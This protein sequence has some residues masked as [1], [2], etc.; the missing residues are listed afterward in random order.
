MNKEGIV[1]E[2]KEYFP[3]N[4]QEMKDKELILRWIQENEDAFLRTNAIGHVTVSAWVVNKE[5]DKVLMVYHNIYD[6][7]SWLGGHADGETDLLSVALR[8]VKEEAGVMNIKPISSD[9]LSLEVLTVD[10][11]EKKGEYVSSHLH[12]NVTCLLEGDSDE[13][14]V[15]KPDENS[16]VSWFDFEEAIEKSSEPWFRE[17]IYKKLNETTRKRIK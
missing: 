6:S 15:V 17:R 7:W 14:V 13:A 4:E 9:I 2:I 8:E 16:A 11:H 1:R 5:H 10:G 3:V 12:F